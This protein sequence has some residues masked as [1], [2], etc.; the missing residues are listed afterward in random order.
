LRI[1]HFTLK[2]TATQR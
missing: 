1:F 2:N